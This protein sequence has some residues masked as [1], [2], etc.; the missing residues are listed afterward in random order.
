VISFDLQCSGNHRFEGWFRSSVDFDQQRIAG[1]IAC[2]YCSDADV[3]KRISAPNIGTKSNQRT[4]SVASPNKH[5]VQCSADANN[6][7]AAKGKSI[8][9]IPAGDSAPAFMP[10]PEQMQQV[11]T[12]LA[13]VQQDMLKGSAYVGGAFPEEARAIHYGETPDRRIHGE[14]S[15]AQ[16]SQLADEGVQ[17]AA[18]PFPIVPDKVKN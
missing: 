3:S 12:K 5:L 17:L 8:A 18:L 9:H 14:A 13:S 7:D 4:P 1:Q 16:V 6:A 11:L 2:P 10:S 15:A